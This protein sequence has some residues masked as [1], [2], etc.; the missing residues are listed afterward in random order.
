MGKGLIQMRNRFGR[1]ALHYCADLCSSH[2]GLEILLLLVNH[3]ALIDEVDGKQRTAFYICLHH[4]K[5]NQWQ[6][7]SD[8][9]LEFTRVMLQFGCDTLNYDLILRTKKVPSLKQQCR[10]YLQSKRKKSFNHLHQK[11]PTELVEYLNRR[12]LR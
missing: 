5:L 8:C 12:C 7:P 9:W 10:L 3:G 4:Y 2:V 6:V 1:T 11:L